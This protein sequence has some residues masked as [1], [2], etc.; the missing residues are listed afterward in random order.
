MSTGTSEL[1]GFCAAKQSSIFA[2]KLV[3]IPAQGHNWNPPE[4][5]LLFSDPRKISACAATKWQKYHVKT[6]FHQKML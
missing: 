5:A 6:L 1:K 2:G 3:K 4:M